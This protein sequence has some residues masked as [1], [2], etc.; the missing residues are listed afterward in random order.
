MRKTKLTD[1]DYYVFCKT[2]LYG[3]IDNSLEKAISVAYRDLCRTITGFS[4]HKKHDEIYENSKKVIFNSINDLLNFDKMTQS[5]FDEWHEKTCKE[6]I[7]SF[8]NQIFTF[9]Q[10]QKWINM[11]LKYLSIFEH[12][13]VEKIYEFC[14]IP[15]DNYILSS[16]EHEF[17]TVWSKINSYENYL[18]FQKSFREQSDEIPLDLEFYLWINSKTK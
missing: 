13:K 17:D 9:G 18:Q 3:K 7:K 2:Y 16:V 15:I 14:H 1:I 6:L 11:T 4:K 10:S 8:E 12:K 5:H